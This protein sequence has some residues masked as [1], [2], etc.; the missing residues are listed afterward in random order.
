MPCSLC[1][2][3]H[4][5]ALHFLLPHKLG[6]QGGKQVKHPML[7]G[8]AAAPQ[9]VASP[10]TRRCVEPAI[11]LLVILQQFCCRCRCRCRCCAAAAAAVPERDKNGNLAFRAISYTPWPVPSDY[12]GERLRIDVGPIAARD[13]R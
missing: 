13:A 7:A 12:E 10:A 4:L 11:S 3:W 8:T 2:C 6:L 9:R 5:P 1:L